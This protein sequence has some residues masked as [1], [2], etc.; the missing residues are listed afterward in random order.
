MSARR[1]W[2]RVQE[3]FVAEGETPVHGFLSGVVACIVLK[4]VAQWP[5]KVLGSGGPSSHPGSVS[6]DVCD[7]HT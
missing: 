1:T 2:Y 5:R 4:Q 3:G 6:Y 7:S